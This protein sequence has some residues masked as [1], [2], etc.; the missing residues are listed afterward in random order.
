MKQ[1]QAM[2]TLVLI[3]GVTYQI[4]LPKHIIAIQT[5]QALAIAQEFGGTIVK[6]DFARIKP[7]EVEGLPF[8]IRNKSDAEYEIRPDIS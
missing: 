3:D 5:K 6:C 8:N 2:V 1:V 7:M 4:A